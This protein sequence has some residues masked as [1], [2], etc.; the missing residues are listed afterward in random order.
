MKLANLDLKLRMTLSTLLFAMRGNDDYYH[1]E[2][3]RGTLI[4]LVL[5][6]LGVVVM[7]AVLWPVPFALVAAGLA[8]LGRRA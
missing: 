6:A 5:L 3:A 1:R 2:G 4:G 7:A 8:C